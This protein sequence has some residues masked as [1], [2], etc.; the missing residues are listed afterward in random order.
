MDVNAMDG[1]YL[2]YVKQDEVQF[3]K[4]PNA[5]AD[6]TDQEVSDLPDTAD[7]QL[8]HWKRVAGHVREQA[9][10]QQNRAEKAEATI[11]RVRGVIKDLIDAGNTYWAKELL[12]ALDLDSGD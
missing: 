11:L 7:Q 8:A 5:L 2:D 10:A 12:V 6:H 4:E 1:T 3:G 9:E